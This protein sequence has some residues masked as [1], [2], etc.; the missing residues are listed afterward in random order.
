MLFNVFFFHINSLFGNML[1]AQLNKVITIEKGTS[2]VT[3]L[4]S[5]T[6]K[7]DEY[8]VTYANVYVRSNSVRFNER[9][10]IIFNTEFTIRYN[11]LSKEINN[12]Y[13]VKYNNQYYSIIEVIETEPRQTIKL[14]GVHYGE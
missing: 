3:S 4:S 12:K 5:P 1:S 14:I 9:E 13:R 7:Y 2:G 8:M 6:L 10:E 11:P